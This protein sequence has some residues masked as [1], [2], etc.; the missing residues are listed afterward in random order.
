MPQW[1][2]L[3]LA[4]LAATLAQQ[5]VRQYAVQACETRHALDPLLPAPAIPLAQLAA[6]IDPASF[7]QFVLRGH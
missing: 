4:T 2:A 7:E 3:D 5:G 6:S 1:T